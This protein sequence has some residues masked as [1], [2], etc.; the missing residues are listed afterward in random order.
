MQ[1]SQRDKI[2]RE[3][4]D[5]MHTILTDEIYHGYDVIIIGSSTDGEAKAQQQSIE[6]IFAGRKTQN[7]SL[8]YKVCVLSVLDDVVGGQII[9]QLNTWNEAVRAFRD[10]GEKNKLPETDLNQLLLKKAVKIA[11]Y[12]NSGKGS[13]FSPAT[14]ALNLSRGDQPLVGHVLNAEKE[15]IRLTL[16][17]AI[18]LQ[19]S[20]LS[21]TNDGE[22]LDC[23]WVNQLGFGTKPFDQLERRSCH[24]AKFVIQIPKNPNYKDLYDYGTAIFREGKME[25]YLA[26]KVLTR[27]NEQTQKYEMNPDYEEKFLELMQRIEKG[28]GF[29]DF[30]SF[31]ISSKLHYALLDYWTN[32]KAIFQAILDHGI[33]PIKRDIDP[34]FVQNLVPLLNG[35]GEKI[36]S[37][38][39][40]PKSSDTKEIEALYQKL[41]SN[42]EDENCQR[43][44]QIC[45]E[46]N[47]EAV[48]ETVEFLAI[49][50][51]DILF[52]PSKVV[53]YIDLGEKSHWFAYKRLLDMGNEKF[54]MLADIIGEVQSI[55]LSG[56]MIKRP[57][58][59]EDKIRAEDARRFR[60]LEDKSLAKF[61]TGETEIILSKEQIQKGWYD[62]NLDIKI[63][64]S[65]LQ[66]HCILLPGSRI[67]NSVVH[68][69][70]GKNLCR[71]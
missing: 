25:K 21:I 34:S 8:Q 41:Y 64:G 60:M 3:N 44:L 11:I 71:K 32:R 7:E 65:I 59:E 26:N 40:I 54:L 2:R 47:R 29:F 10:W 24:F 45:Y 12:H 30:G 69:S 23:F 50:Q 9:G 48:L 14:Q 52:D 37:L 49:F 66:G 51:K 19:T 22:Y 57:A 39:E 61:Y 38:L 1:I 67:V 28:E 62:E 58:N 5:R 20:S 56:Q 35:L 42:I 46:K 53:S 68:D 16:L 31:T 63:E 70:Q 43:A 15:K 13:R 55:S 6:N 18:I 4:I 27:K 36:T 17:Q 33:S